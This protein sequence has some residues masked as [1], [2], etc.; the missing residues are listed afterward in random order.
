VGF[1][2]FVIGDASAVD[3]DGLAKLF[4][5]TLY[6]FDV[7]NSD[8]LCSS[9]GFDLEI[10]ER[11]RKLALFCSEGVIDGHLS[12][13]PGA[14]CCFREWWCTGVEHRMIPTLCNAAHWLRH[15][16]IAHGV[17]GEKV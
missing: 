10:R 2:N 15:K 4:K 7:H 12:H 14:L 3:V 11:K 6:R 9:S 13:C 16:L 1:A 5:A 8:G 17:Y